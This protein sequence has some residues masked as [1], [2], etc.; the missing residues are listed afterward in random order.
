MEKPPP[1]FNPFSPAKTIR[2]KRRRAFYPSSIHTSRI[3]IRTYIYIYI[4]TSGEKK[5]GWCSFRARSRFHYRSGIHDDAGITNKIPCGGN[6]FPSGKESAS[7][8]LSLSLPSLDKF[9]CQRL[10]PPVRRMTLRPAHLD[11]NHAL[12]YSSSSADK[13]PWIIYCF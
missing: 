4:Y 6:G 9:N 2:Q 8:S 11:G 13:R 1:T 3:H 7:P 5:G 10:R 12:N